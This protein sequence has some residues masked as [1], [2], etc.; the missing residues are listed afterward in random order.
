M[1]SGGSARAIAHLGVIKRL[2][3]QGLRPDLIIMNSMGSIIGLL[4]AAGVPVSV[5]EDL[6]LTQ[7][8]YTLFSLKLP[9]GGG[10]AD[11]RKLS[12]LR[13]DLVGE[14]DISSLPIPVIV[15]AEDLRTRRKILLAK[16]DFNFIMQAAVAV[17]GFFEP[18][19]LDGFLLIDGGVTNLVPVEP[20][21]ALA[22]V[23][24]A[25]TSLYDRALHLNDPI[26]IM[27]MSLNLAK[28]RYALQEIERFSPFWIR[29]DV[30]QLSYMAWYQQDDIIRRGYRSCDAVMADLLAYLKEE[31]IEPSQQSL[32]PLDGARLYRARWS[33]L[34][35]NM[36]APYPVALKEGYG[37]IHLH[38]VL[39]KRPRGK[40]HFE[41]QNYMAVSFLYESGYTGFR[42]GGLASV[43]GKLGGLIYLETYLRGKIHISLDNYYFVRME[44]Q[45]LL[46]SYSYHHIS[47]SWPFLAGDSLVLA[48]FLSL[49]YVRRF[50]QLEED[51]YLSSGVRVRFSRIGARSL[52]EERIGYFFQL[53]GIQGISNELMVR[54]QFSRY[55]YGFTR[56]LLKITLGQEYEG[57]SPGPNDYWRGVLPDRTS[58]SF[59]LFNNDIIVLFS[60]FQP[61]L[62]EV[63]IV[64]DI[65]A[66]LFF[67]LI[68]EDFHTPSRRYVPS[69]GL[70]FRSDIVLV[71]LLPTTVTIAGGYDFEA[72]TPFF[73]FYLGRI[74]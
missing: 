67:D 6:L 70:G 24:V 15:V 47:S 65:E 73:S 43:Q 61:T 45:S 38:P 51:L 18:V 14:A 3:E 7:D 37:G 1:L 64:K 68:I 9:I 58:G 20:F 32:H 69:V 31:G 19:E 56:S 63:L 16:G 12:A 49:E 74:Y 41:Q 13:Y 44:Q 59:V 57:I 42:M 4:Y 28:T 27:M 23:L 48:P 62:A 22:D 10:L 40:N 11:M 25:A 2:E 39:L 55:L 29:E 66:S 33:R 52:F 46:E 72:A 8:L 53:P 71:G 17:P 34:K 30:E 21:V 35:R 36:R 54:G 5:I 26:S 50:L 60:D